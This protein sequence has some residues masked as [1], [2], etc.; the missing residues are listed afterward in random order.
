MAPPFETI[1]KI[2]ERFKEE[3]FLERFLC[4]GDKNWK[5]RDRFKVKIFFRDH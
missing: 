1:E 3:S 4:F 5:N 2:R